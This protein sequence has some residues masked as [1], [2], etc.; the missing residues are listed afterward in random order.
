[1]VVP[2]LEY[3]FKLG[4]V[5]LAVV[6]VLFALTN[7]EKPPVTVIPETNV[8]VF[9]AIPLPTIAGELVTPEKSIAAMP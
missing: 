4:S 5:I 6:K 2:T 8:T 7:I 9:V 1:M 3:T